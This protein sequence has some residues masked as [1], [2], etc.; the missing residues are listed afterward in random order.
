MIIP[1]SDLCAKTRGIEL[2]D[3]GFADV[4]IFSESSGQLVRMIMDSVKDTRYDHIMVLSSV[5]LF[6]QVKNDNSLFLETARDPEEY[7]ERMETTMNNLDFFFVNNSLST[8][9]QHSSSIFR[10]REWINP[11]IP[12]NVWFASECAR[13]RNS[14]LIYD[15]NGETPSEGL[16]RS[17]GSKLI[18]IA[19]K[20]GLLL[21]NG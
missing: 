2:C 20:Q 12:V 4:E 13:M 3:D 9:F 5:S 18:G 17:M 8:I 15:V 19:E 7:V 14:G 11:L 16:M 1:I 6:D 21:A 10:W